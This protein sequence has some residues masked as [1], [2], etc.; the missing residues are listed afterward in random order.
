[1]AESLR[2]DAA[3][4]QVP[5]FA[6]LRVLEVAGSVAG[7]YAAKLF[8]DFGALVVKI[9]PPGGDPLRQAGPAV[10]GS[11]ALFALTNTSKRSLVLDMAGNPADA[12]RFGALALGAD[13]VIESSS[14]EPL[15]PVSAEL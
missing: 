15:R 5:P 11:G 12:A 10:N 1:M 2:R 14:A 4:G 13:V 7:A 6:A 3:A 8:A 9:E